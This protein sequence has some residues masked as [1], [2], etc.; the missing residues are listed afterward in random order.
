MNTLEHNNA[1]GKGSSRGFDNPTHHRNVKGDKGNRWRGGKAS[2][3]MLASQNKANIH[4]HPI[5]PIF[6]YKI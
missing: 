1:G 6:D 5:R 4:F 2:S 3:S